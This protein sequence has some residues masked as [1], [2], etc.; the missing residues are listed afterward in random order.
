[1]A[2]IRAEEIDAVCLDAAVKAPERL[3]QFF[4]HAV[5]DLDGLEMALHC[6]RESIFDEA[7]QRMNMWH[8]E[9]AHLGYRGWAESYFAEAQRKNQ[10]TLPGFLS[11]EEQSYLEAWRG[12][13]RS[14]IDRSSRIVEERHGAP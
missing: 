4:M 1:M 5:H 10:F 11:A 12:N 14:L 8:T 3:Q 13:M 2:T 6:L 7:L 9:F